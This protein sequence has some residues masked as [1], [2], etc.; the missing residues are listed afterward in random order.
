M[1]TAAV[2]GASGFVG[3][4]AAHRLVADGMSVHPLAAPRLRTA[5]RGPDALRADLI[6]QDRV[7][8]ALAD[9]LREADADVVLNAAGLAAPGAPASD[10]LFGGNAL[11][12]AVVVAAAARARVP[13]VVHVSS[14]AVQGRRTVLDETAEHEPFS[15]YSQSKALGES[16]VLRAGGGLEV[17]VFRPTS[18]HG[19][20]RGVTA[21]LARL[22]ASPVSS[23][24]GAGDHPTPQVHI[25]DVAAALGFVVRRV[26]RDVPAIV[27]QPNAGMTGRRVLELLGGRTP[28]RV[29]PAAAG[30]LT[31][32]LARVAAA[33]GRGVAV[34]RRLEMLW[35]GQDQ[36]DG[37]L[38]RTGF[39]PASQDDDWHAL[40]L[41][42]RRRAS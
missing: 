19:L 31:A 22:A 3:A 42:A 26:T 23:V 30:R 39:R 14:A 5:A 41:A 17:T 28:R 11:L 36:V 34:H 12:P 15:P 6:A 25:E 40:G 35:F 33:T 27:L 7:V 18:V 2:L 38:V 20:G 8:D 29:P 1:T 4:A 21:T 37:W 32:G 24:A 13:R 9:A 10:G 16:A